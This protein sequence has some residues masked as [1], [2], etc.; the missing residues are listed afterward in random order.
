MMIETLISWSE[1]AR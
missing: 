1:F